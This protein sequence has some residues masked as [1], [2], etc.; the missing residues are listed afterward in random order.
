MKPSAFAYHRPESLS[1]ALELLSRHGETGKL[2]AGGQSLM[3]MLSMRLAVADELIDLNDVAE[4]AYVRRAEDE[5]VAVGAMTRQR[6]LERSDSCPALVRDALAHVGH[7]QIRNRG[8]VGGSLAHADP[9]AELGL[10][11]LALGGA[12]T[13][14]RVGATR[15][16]A[17]DDFF[18]TYYT[19]ALEPDELVT[20]VRFDALRPGDGCGFHEVARR[21]GDYA[22]VA[23]ACVVRPEGVRIAVSGGSDRPQR[24]LA[25]ERRLADHGLDDAAIDAAVDELRDEWEPASDAHATADYRRRVAGV[26]LSR[27]ARDARERAR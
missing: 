23:V 24:A 17:A 1:E 25:A 20:E 19:T 9:V 14:A 18:R 15:T 16:I 12:V 6:T 10:T 21:R 22:L 27:A 3:P 11:W 4:L 26:L 7:W 13:A 8:T 2:L 5:G